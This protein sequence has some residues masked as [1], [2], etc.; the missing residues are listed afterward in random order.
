MKIKLRTVSVPSFV[1]I[2]SDL[3]ND[4]RDTD[5][6]KTRKELGKSVQ[7]KIGVMK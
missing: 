6:R 1:I 2:D 4:S 7:K 5:N 3:F